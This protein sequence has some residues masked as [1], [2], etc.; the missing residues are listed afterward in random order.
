VSR[1]IC[2][3]NRNKILTEFIRTGLYDRR[4]E[5]YKTES[6]SMDILI[7]S[8]LERLLFELAG[9][10]SAILSEWMEK[11]ASR[12][13]YTISPSALDHL[14]ALFYGGFADRKE[15]LRAVKEAFEKYGYLMDP[16]S[17]VGY[18]V[19]RRYREETGDGSPALLASTASPF[20][21]NRAVLEALGRDPAPKN[22]F[23][24]LEELSSLSGRPVPAQLAELKSLPEIHKGVCEKQEM[25]DVLYRFL[26]LN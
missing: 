18:S 11:L 21:F 4:R 15:T 23:S 1:L 22:E 13:W 26:R 5:F 10:Q 16:H 17:A 20:K 12:G 7:S 24:L 3:S 2:A 9:R 25:A 8:N 19:G 6:P 14:Q